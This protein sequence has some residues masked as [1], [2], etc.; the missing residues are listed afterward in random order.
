MVAVSIPRMPQDEGKTN[1]PNSAKIQA[2]VKQFEELLARSLN[3]G[4]YGKVQY[5]VTI[6]DGSIQTAEEQII[7]Q[8]RF[9][10]EKT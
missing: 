10:K 4:F 7:R 6:H 5:T 8:R 2:A 1:L 3:R 9:D